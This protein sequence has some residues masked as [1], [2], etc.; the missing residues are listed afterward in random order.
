MN[1]LEKLN[2]NSTSVDS[3]TI[4]LKHN[5]DDAFHFIINQNHA[6]LTLSA[7]QVEGYLADNFNT[8]NKLD[9]TLSENQMFIDLLIDVSE[10]LNLS[11]YFKRFCRIKIRA[12][13]SIS[14][15]NEAASLYMNRLRSFQDFENILEDFLKKLQFAFTY[16]EDTNKRVVA[17]FFNFYAN[18][19]LDFG[20][21]NMPKLIGFVHKIEQEAK[22]FPFLTSSVTDEIFELDISKDYKFAVKSI[23]SIVDKHLQR[24]DIV[25]SFNKA[26]FLIELDTEYANSLSFVNKDLHDIRNLASSFYGGADSIFHSLGR[27]VTILTEEQQLY[28]YFHSYGNMHL[29]KCNY[30]FSFLS[31]EFFFNKIEIIDWG[32]GQAMASMSYLDFLLKNDINQ[33][34]QRINLNEPSEISLR[35]GA[36]H[37]TKY[38]ERIDLTTTNKDLDSIKGEDFKDFNNPNVKLHLFSNILD[39]DSYSTK[40]L[41]D[42][43]ISSFKGVNYFIV[44]SPYITELKTNRIN[45]FISEFANMSEFEILESKNKKKGEWKNNWTLVLRIFKV[46]LGQK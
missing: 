2:S 19:I 16:E 14:K 21:M 6:T 42:L 3:L 29:A 36:L 38:N 13:L 4:F 25:L 7:G 28:A 23:H 37:L 33:K 39:I 31:T 41:S 34:L 20:E 5:I 46:K 24:E 22:I 44:I 1:I 43:I 18:I 45:N 10:R 15:K 11:F 9:L 32:C 8:I 30:A 35:R 40:Q 12:E 17:L 26:T 27:G